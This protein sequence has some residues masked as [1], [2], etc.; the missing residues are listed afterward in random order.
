MKNLLFILF[1]F[2]SISVFAQ[3]QPM[4]KTNNKI[5]IR[6][7]LSIN[8]VE[9]DSTASDTVLVLNAFNEI[10][11]KK[12]I[13]GGSAD[14]ALFATKF[15]LNDKIEGA[16]T[17]DLVTKFTGVNTT[18]PTNIYNDGTKTGFGTNSP[19]TIL[20]LPSGASAGKLSWL[21]YS[22]Q[23]AS[24]PWQIQ[25]DYGAYGDFAILTASA[26]NYT[27]NKPRLYL[28]ENGDMA[29]NGAS[30]LLG[31]GT[32]KAPL[33]INSSGTS[34]ITV[35]RKPDA[36]NFLQGLYLQDKDLNSGWYM[37][38]NSAGNQAFGW[39]TAGNETSATSGAANAEFLSI[40]QAGNVAAKKFQ[41]LNNINGASTLR[42]TNLYPGT[43]AVPATMNLDFEGY[44]SQVKARFLVE[45]K[46]SSVAGS[47]VKIQVL[48]NSA[49]LT[50][51]I[52]MR[53][54]SGVKTKNRA[55]IM[56]RVATVTDIATD[57]NVQSYGVLPTNTAAE[58]DAAI[59]AMI[60]A[61]SAGST[62][63]WPSGTYLNN[64]ISVTKPLDFK[65]HSKWSSI[66]KNVGTGTT[67]IDISAGVE[68]ARMYNI[69][70]W[71]D[72]TNQF[73]SDATTG[74]G[75]VFHESS[76]HWNFDNIWMRGHG[77]YFFWTD[78]TGN[79]NNIN[80]TNSEL[81]YGKKSAIRFIQADFTKQMNGINISGCNISGFGGHGI[82]VWGQSMGI[83][84]NTVQ[85]CKKTGIQIN[86][87]S[88][89]Y[90]SSARAIRV[91]GNYFEACNEGFIYCKAIVT[92]SGIFAKYRYLSSI[93]IQG[94]FGGYGK[95]PGDEAIDQSAHALCEVAAPG[96]YSYGN[97][98]VTGFSYKDND[99][100]IGDS[101]ADPL[102][103]KRIFNGNG[104]LSSNSTVKKNVPSYGDWHEYIGLGQAT[105]EGDT[106]VNV[107]TAAL[108]TKT[109]QVANTEFVDSAAHKIYNDSTE[110]L[111]FI[112]GIVYD[113]TGRYTNGYSNV[114]I[115]QYW[116]DSVIVA[117]GGGGGISGLTTNYVPVATSS[118]AI[119]NSIIQQATNKIGINVT[120]STDALEVKTPGQG[121]LRFGGADGLTITALNSVGAAGNVNIGGN[122]GVLGGN[123]YA[124][125]F[126]DPTTNTQAL[127]LSSTTASLWTNSTQRLLI[128]NAGDV[129]VSA[130]L[131]STSYFSTTGYQ[132]VTGVGTSTIADNTNTYIYNPA[133]VTASFTIS[134]P[135]APVDGQ[136]IYIAFGG[137]IDPGDPVVTSL[138]IAPNVGYTLYEGITPTTANGGD[139]L[140]Y[141]VEGTVIRRYK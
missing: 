39:A 127:Q 10:V 117:A 41:V 90:S 96:W 123:V 73:G 114:L 131:K 20:S 87:S 70:I 37:G 130:G 102:T 88:G 32:Y 9:Y 139:V 53:S 50:T 77:D 18:A 12:I 108:G 49:A 42:V 13:S 86:G 91:I 24:R 35:M 2:I 55:G 69:G 84:R 82:E 25:S 28:S 59:A 26:Q 62:L 134:M 74:K 129:T 43:T 92:E 137:T 72:G 46:S 121:T 63:Y 97:L 133:T 98:Q 19:Q 56:S 93:T 120:P 71:G 11:K 75:V 67:A 79:V 21:Y 116:L 113:T 5:I 103:I 135:V 99:F 15:D 138:A 80:I 89:L 115:D 119:G 22:P 51:E 4:G 106:I 110:S 66:I 7:G 30:T 85:A 47:K 132:V 140:I 27:F 109:K 1:S 95:I 58:N 23:A 29:I 8:K 48:D 57:I 141:H 125:N 112:S 34:G 64:G 65:G 60:T 44:S 136:W 81:E 17:A 36:T 6:G 33:T 122:L 54:D 45:E 100:G 3:D 128:S 111:R 101:I 118:T 16:G 61:V 40:T 76:N 104:V 38:I 31:D 107:I 124:S 52:E 105:V 14:S 78:T 94:N 68:R 83:E 126:S